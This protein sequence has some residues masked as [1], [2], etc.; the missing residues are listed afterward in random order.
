MDSYSPEADMR[1]AGCSMDATEREEVLRRQFFGDSRNLQARSTEILK[2]Y[3]SIAAILT[4]L[5]GVRT[6]RGRPTFTFSRVNISSL[7]DTPPS[8]S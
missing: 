4:Y 7:M 1:L 2:Y 3:L 8:S 6:V 5:A